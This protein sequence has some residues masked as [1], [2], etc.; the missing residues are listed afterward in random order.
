MDGYKVDVSELRHAERLL[1]NLGRDF[2]AS[3]SLKYS[4][5]TSE[6]GNEEL[7]QAL[8]EFHGQSRR[9]TVGLCVDAAE[10]G[11]RLRG[12]AADYER[13]DQAAAN[14]IAGLDIVDQA[15]R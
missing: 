13:H 3:A 1:R 6:V 5:A 4:I 11:T 8:A 15:R 14:L 12:T 9:V 7:A 2:G 10:A